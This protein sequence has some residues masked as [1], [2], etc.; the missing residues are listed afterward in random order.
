MISAKFERTLPVSP[1]RGM[2]IYLEDHWKKNIGTWNFA[3]EE[4][5]NK[6]MQGAV[7]YFWP[8]NLKERLI[9]VEKPNIAQYALFQGLFPLSDHLGTVEFKE[10]ETPDSCIFVYEVQAKAWFGFQF[11]LQKVL[12][13][14]IV[15]IVSAIEKRALE[16]EKV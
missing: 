3:L 12:D 7:R 4:E 2:E 14:V 5:G 11:V 10:A 6:D 16:V 1:E 13:N 9:K 15:K 8:F